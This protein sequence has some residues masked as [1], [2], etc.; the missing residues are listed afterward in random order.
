MAHGQTHILNDSIAVDDEDEKD[1]G[2]VDKNIRVLITKLKGAHMNE[3]GYDHHST[4]ELEINDGPH[5]GSQ[6]QLCL[7]PNFMSTYSGLTPV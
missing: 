3:G 5:E 4:S 7:C 6:S 1:L 2:T